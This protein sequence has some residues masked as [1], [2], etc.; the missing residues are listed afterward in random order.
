M[1]LYAWIFDFHL[2]TQIDFP[3]EPLM[4][5]PWATV[6]SGPQHRQR[7]TS[8]WKYQK[9]HAVTIAEGYLLAVEP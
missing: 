2:R 9:L 4:A 5:T 8:F 3:P 1:I 7:A 6:F